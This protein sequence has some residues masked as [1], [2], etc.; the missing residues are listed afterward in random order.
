MLPPTKKA[1]TQSRNQGDGGVAFFAILSYCFFETLI[2]IT[3]VNIFILSRNV[4]IINFYGQYKIMIEIKNMT[5]VYPSGVKALDDISFSV[6]DGEF[7][8]IVGRS[9][10]GKST[11]MNILGCLDTPTLGEYYLNN[12]KICSVGDSSL[13]KIRNRSIGFVFQSY[14]LIPSLTA[15]ENVRLPLSYRGLTADECEKRV[16]SALDRVGLGSLA[17]RFPR[18][19]SGGQQ[20]RIAIARAVAADPPLILADE[21][22]GNLD[23]GIRDEIMEIFHELNKNGRTVVLITHDE[24]VAAT[25]HRVITINNG[26]LIC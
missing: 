10:S 6:A 20:Q 23:S 17:K 4:R 8:A 19:M 21:P 7:S 18:E 2:K 24:Q 3:S 11:L 16:S 13:A 9:G 5:K 25:A 15:E 14:N 22:T 1:Q 26:K 12:E